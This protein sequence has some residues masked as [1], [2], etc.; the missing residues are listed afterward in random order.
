MP[1]RGPPGTEIRCDGRH[2]RPSLQ[3]L[4]PSLQSRDRRIHLRRGRLDEHEL[5]LD[6]RLRAVGGRLERLGDE[7]EQPHGVGTRQRRGLLLEPAVPLGGDPKLG[8]DLARDLDRQQLAPV[9]LEVSQHLPGVAAGLRQRRGRAKGSGG[10]S[11]D[12]RVDRPEQLLR[13]GHAEHGQHVGGL[14]RPIAGVCDQLLERAERVPEA[15]GCVPRDQRKRAPIDGDLLGLHD[16]L[17][18]GRDLLDR[19]P[20]E[21][22]A[23]AAVHDRREHLLGLGRG[24]HEDRPRRGLLE[25]LQE[26][27]PRL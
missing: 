19:G 8:Y 20:R 18:D 14:D 17:K 1:R 4:N 12:H 21:V 6:P 13:V 7:I 3:P 24:E 2:G 27:V 25:R 11:R 23:V 22:E 10:V 15:P 5:E 9:H 16:P 26:G